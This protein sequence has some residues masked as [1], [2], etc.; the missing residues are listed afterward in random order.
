MVPCNT[1]KNPPK[2]YED[3]Y[4]FYFESE[5]ATE[6]CDE[7]KRVVFYWMEQGVRI[8]R[9]DNSAHEAVRFLGVVD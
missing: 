3:I 4:P 9:V 5:Y 1:R 8:F 2:K 7:L 6:L